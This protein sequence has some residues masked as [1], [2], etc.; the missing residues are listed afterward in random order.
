MHISL[1][2]LKKG[3]S[4]PMGRI[5]VAR[6]FAGYLHF[7]T[8]FSGGELKSRKRYRQSGA[9]QPANRM[10]L[11]MKMLLQFSACLWSM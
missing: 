5:A 3:W 10:E 1:A 2:V 6:A 4:C 8:P 11:K 9:G 7:P